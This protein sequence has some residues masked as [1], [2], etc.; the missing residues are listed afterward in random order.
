MKTDNILSFIGLLAIFSVTILAQANPHLCPSGR[1]I[2]AAIR[3]KSLVKFEGDRYFSNST[4]EYFGSF[5][6]TE[7]WYFSISVWDARNATDAW[8]RF[9]WW[10]DMIPNTP[11][12]AVDRLYT[13]E[14][15]YSI[16]ISDLRLGYGAHAV[17]KSQ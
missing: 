16:G 14:C 12:Y 11:Q 5:D 6:T 3:D 9:Q 15:E 4:L 2:K 1:G 13:W 7:T 17:L 8:N 10:F